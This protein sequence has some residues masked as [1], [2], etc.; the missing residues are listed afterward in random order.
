MKAPNPSPHD[1]TRRSIFH[2]DFTEIGGVRHRKTVRCPSWE[3]DPQA[4]LIG[5][6]ARLAELTLDAV[7]V[8]SSV[9]VP[10][11]PRHLKACIDG[12]GIKGHR[13]QCFPRWTSVEVLKP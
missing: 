1:A 10:E 8:R 6:Q 11:K 12:R 13:C 2:L 4:S 3:R 7:I 9:S 5:L